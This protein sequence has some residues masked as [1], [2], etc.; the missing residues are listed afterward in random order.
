MAKRNNQINIF[1]EEKDLKK[2]SA[3]ELIESYNIGN[4]RSDLV[5]VQYPQLA[6]NDQD[7]IIGE[8]NKFFDELVEYYGIRE[9]KGYSNNFY[10]C[11]LLPIA[12][13][14]YSLNERIDQLTNNG[15]SARNINV[16]FPSRLIFSHFYSSYFMAEHESQG[17]FFY[18]RQYAFQ[19]YLKKLCELRGV[20]ISYK[21]TSLGLSPYFFKPTRIFA[22]VIFR[23]L[24]FLKYRL[25]ILLNQPETKKNIKKNHNCGRVLVST[26]SRSQSEAIEGFIKNIG[27]PSSWIFG[28]SSVDVASN[29]ELGIEIAKEA[30]L[31]NAHL[32]KPQPF[33]VVANDIA[34]LTRLPLR[35]KY[36]INVAGIDLVLNQAVNEVMFMLSELLAY[37][38]QL[39]DKLESF[40]DLKGVTLFTTE[41]KSPHIYVEA[42]LAKAY[43]M[44]CVQIMQCDQ[45]YIDL[46]CP[47]H[48]DVFIADTVESFK[49]FKIKW[50]RHQQKVHY[51]G[52]IKSFN[53][54]RASYEPKKQPLSKKSVLCVFL[55]C[56]DLETNLKVLNEL[57]G[58]EKSSEIIVKIHPRD[59]IK[60]YKEYFTHFEFIDPRI[61]KNIL[62]SRFDVAITFP[63]AV[64][65][66]LEIERK[67]FSLL[68][69][70][71][72]AA[73]TGRDS[74]T[75]SYRVINDPSKI[76]AE[77]EA[78]KLFA[79]LNE[80][81]VNQ[82][83]YIS[84]EPKRLLSKILN[85]SL[86]GH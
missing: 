42:E 69:F 15:M 70:G 46:P 66:D 7:I 47:V 19:P 86:G 40:S 75:Q 65:L 29:H 34:I 21:G 55:Q 33:Q 50:T 59:K 23:F 3:E 49:N 79:N 32:L 13:Y 6:V 9:L 20:R 67:P 28:Y 26:R 30:P 83:S 48:G 5:Q 52:T 72:W 73:S 56:D 4:V 64:T 80:L 61:R 58:V 77:V 37:R 10:E 82:N 16:F 1:F 44:K 2:F 12:R 68:N 74:S 18:Y 63:S 38:C 35:K 57:L 71:R 84:L 81:N 22:V 41:Q 62:Y 54:P 78:L 11:S 45:A 76:L 43:G 51:F 85:V 53:N 24:K 27:E 31:I 39:S 60:Y 17:E 25:V 8:T 14:L 36:I